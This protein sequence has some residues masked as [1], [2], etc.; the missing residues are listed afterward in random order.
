M[1]SNRKVHNPTPPW[2]LGV[3]TIEPAICSGR[4]QCH[5][6]HV[7]YRSNKVLYHLFQVEKLARSN[8][9][10]TGYPASG[11]IRAVS[12]QDIQG[13]SCV[14]AHRRH[15]LDR[16]GR[17]PSSCSSFDGMMIAFANASC[18]SETSSEMLGFRSSHLGYATVPLSLSYF[19]KQ[20]TAQKWS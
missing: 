10:S 2:G 6:L 3:G 7:V 20:A 15:G 14:S 4:T 12:T 18:G 16:S 13:V 19:L 11:Y 17:E 5:V 1:R 9:G 8:L